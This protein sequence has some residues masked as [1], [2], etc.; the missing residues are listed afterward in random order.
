MTWCE[1]VT[2]LGCS[3]SFVWHSGTLKIQRIFYHYIITSFLKEMLHHLYLLC[4][5]PVLVS[6]FLYNKY[7]INVIFLWDFKHTLFI[8][9]KAYMYTKS[10]SFVITKILRKQSFT[11]VLRC[12]SHVNKSWQNNDHTIWWLLFITTIITIIGP[13]HPGERLNQLGQ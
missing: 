1:A 7:T 5:G 4:L 2:S 9:D 12:S 10:C 11:I 13:R 8:S 6:D 3:W